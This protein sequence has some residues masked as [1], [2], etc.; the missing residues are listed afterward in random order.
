MVRFL[1]LSVLGIVALCLFTFAGIGSYR[2]AGYIDLSETLPD[3][4]SYR[5]HP[6]LLDSAFH[7]V[8]SIVAES[9][10]TPL[11][12]PVGIDA[13]HWQRP[14]PARINVVA[15]LREQSPHEIV[16]DLSIETEDGEI[17]ARV[18]GLRARV[19]TAQSLARMLGTE[20]IALQTLVLEWEDVPRTPTQPSEGL[21]VL[22]TGGKV[23]TAVAAARRCD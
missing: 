4:T 11:F 1:V 3:M 9:D 7:T 19:A 2:P 6:A 17:V 13:I 18:E 8:G 22:G 23:S 20:R 5:L 16:S 10:E 15:R 12:L 21:L 14:A